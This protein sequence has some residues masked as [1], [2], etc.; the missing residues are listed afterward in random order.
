MRLTVG[1]VHCVLSN[2][3]DSSTGGIVAHKYT[4]N[5]FFLSGDH[6]QDHSLYICAIVI[7]SL[8]RSLL[9]NK[10]YFGLTEFPIS[11]FIIFSSQLSPQATYHSRDY[12]SSVILKYFKK[13][14]LSK[15]QTQSVQ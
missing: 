5:W 9:N 13:I 10:T 4:C 8:P 11:S 6:C 1:E 12:S 3:N 7:L 14:K 15:L 2:A